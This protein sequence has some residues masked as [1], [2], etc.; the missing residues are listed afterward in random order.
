MATFPAYGGARPVKPEPHEAPKPPG[1]I[2]SPFAQR[3]FLWLWIAALVSNIGTW[4]QNIGAAWLMT[5]LSASPLM[6]ALIQTAA[7][8]PL[9]MLALPAGALADVVD[10]RRLLIFSQG[11]MLVAAG[12]LGALTLAHATTPWTLLVLSFALGLG[13]A[14]NAPAWQAIVPEVVTRNDL[15][16]AIAGLGV[17]F[18]IARALGPALGGV[19]VSMIGAGANFLLNATSFLAVMAVLYSWKR[20]Y[21]PGTLPAERVM[22]AMRA[23]LR[24]VR[25]APPLRAVLAR[26]AAF[27]V[28]ASALWAVM[29][30]LA[31]YE[32]GLGA[33]G[34]GLLLAFFG[35]G[36]VGG[37]AMLPW[38]DR[39]ASRDTV[40]AV[41]TVIFAAASAALAIS[42]SVPVSCA[43]MAAGGAAWTVA[44]S[45]LNVAAQ[46]AVPQWVR[47][48]ALSCYQIVMQGGMT[49]GSVLW[50]E[51][52]THWGVPA[53]LLYAAPVMGV[54]ML[55]MIRYRLANAGTLALDPIPPV[56]MP[57]VAGEIAPDSGPVLVSVEYRI[58]RAHV[59]EFEH[60]MLELRTIRRRDG[61]TFW[62]LFA[63]VADPSRYVEFFS[64]D[65]WVEHMRQHGRGTLADLEL[66]EYVRSFH[67]GKE[68]PIVTHHIAARVIQHP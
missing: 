3:L 17:N 1:S 67:I 36:A 13:S 46:L 34:Y 23:G 60:T 12:L 64:V 62:G 53:S 52:A 16:P 47:G 50:G 33:T 63:D 38:W 54:G 45:E 24:Y 59:R 31:R 26:T 21:N 18:N 6:V 2:W 7:S 43:L 19:V 28:G 27:I 48:R 56:P 39:H 37:G 14:M 51:V 22:G 40:V 44:M 35:T 41:S 49:L 25:Y 57:E 5:T 55:A 8:L 30:L 29:P 4:M 58:D 42:R 15:A 10:R 66:Q 61:A 20:D 9:F 11:W 32:L 68:P 65:S